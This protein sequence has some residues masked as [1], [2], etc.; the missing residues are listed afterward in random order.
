[1]AMP[2]A[3]KTYAFNVDL[4]EPFYNKFVT[5]FE[6]HGIQHIDGVANAVSSAFERGEAVYAAD[7]AHWS[8][9]GHRISAGVLGDRLR[10]AAKS[11]GLKEHK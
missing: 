7:G 10:R 2:A 4:D 5:L 9:A 11:A 1:M 8:A 3:T 6:R